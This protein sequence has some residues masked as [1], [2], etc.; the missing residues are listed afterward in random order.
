MT[1][2]TFN[3]ISASRTAAQCAF[4]YLG[5]APCNDTSISIVGNVRSN[6]CTLKKVT[7]VSLVLVSMEHNT[8]SESGRWYEHTSQQPC[9]AKY[10]HRSKCVDPHFVPLD[11]FSMTSTMFISM[12]EYHSPHS[13]NTLC[14]DHQC[15]R[16]F[17]SYQSVCGKLQ[18]LFTLSCAGLVLWS[19]CKCRSQGHFETGSEGLMTLG[20]V[21]T[22]CR[23]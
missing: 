19:V 6:S 13:K 20:A 18:P 15:H 2:N 22:C 10:I 17:W 11:P 21:A 5:A 8:S 12:H 3:I 1:A 23:S 7:C 4:N 14:S 16:S 9:R